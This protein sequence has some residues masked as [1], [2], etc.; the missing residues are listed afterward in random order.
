LSSKVDATF[1]VIGNKA[2]TVALSNSL[3]DGSLAHAYALIGPNKIGKSTLA[4]RLAQSVNCV[5]GNEG[6]ACLQCN[7]CTRI[8]G[9]NHADVVILAPD[10]NWSSD[11]DPDSYSDTGTNI[12]RLKKLERDVSL[13][14]YEGKKK[15]FILKNLDEMRT[16]NFNVLLKVLEEP[17]TDVLFVLTANHYEY[18]PATVLSRCQ[19]F[20][21]L[22]VSTVEIIKALMTE[23]SIPEA[24]ATSIANLSDGSIGWAIEAARDFSIAEQYLKERNDFALVLSND[25][26]GKIFYGERI[27]NLFWRNRD[28]VFDQLSMMISWWRT[29]LLFLQGKTNDV[30][31][32]EKEIIEVVCEAYTV[33]NIVD[34]IKKTRDT[35]DYL[36]SIN[37]PNPRIALE[38]LMISIHS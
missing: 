28:Y 30:L 7:Q 6:R 2:I 21:F 8:E 36:H 12:K 4:R 3:R 27:A 33:V 23:E 35:M 25:L 14:P 32:E 19:R 1:G 16:E 15:V 9:M 24:R 13:K 38:S 37:N 31:A 11:E 22:P 26:Q 18:I 17:S 5:A 29:M 20:D 10:K 34:A